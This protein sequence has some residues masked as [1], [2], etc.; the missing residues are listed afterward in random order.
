[1]RRTIA[2]CVP[3]LVLIALSGSPAPAQSW[4]IELK[5]TADGPEVARSGM[6]DAGFN[7]V[8]AEHAG[9]KVACGP[10]VDCARVAVKILTGSGS[11]LLDLGTGSGALSVFTIPKSAATDSELALFYDGAST[12]L[13]KYLLAAGASSVIP[14]EPSPSGDGGG[15]TVT[16]PLAELLK[17]ECRA[18]GSA[19]YSTKRNRGAIVVSP[20]GQVSEGR[21]VEKF[22]ENDTLE[23]T[24]FGHK[25]LL[26]QLKVRRKSP[27]GTG[28]L[29]IVGE[30]L[31]IPVASGLS[32][33]SGSDVCGTRTFT[34]NNFAPGRGEVEIAVHDG[35]GDT[36]LG[37]FEFKVN[38]LYFGIFSLGGVWTDMVDPEFKLVSDGADSILSAGNQGDNEFLYSVMFTPYIWGK[39][40]LEKKT[41]W[42]RR[43]NPTVGLV[44][45]DVEDH[46]LVGLTFD[47][48]RGFLVTAGKHY[49]KISV[50]DE[51]SGL[52]EGDV[53]TGPVD[54]LPI[55]DSW[56][57]DSFVSVSIDLRVAVKM[58]ASAF[59]GA[60]GGK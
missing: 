48:P 55:S 49:R 6:D 43:I 58:F 25:A 4:T 10:D 21:G 19:R 18:R 44:L 33:Q 5:N 50:I 11:V 20:T 31:K 36:V 42:L 52:S 13:T 24:V 22:D 7:T 3:A 16:R 40:D 45:D 15:G 12:P 51:N 8:R 39:R 46:G 28:E 2:W 47:L 26:D 37:T 53:F 27:F 57:D 9:L 60:G 14:V 41:G 56:E 34:L 54:Q 29:R 17:A 30:G 38:P 23:V 59:R 35:S 1:M 32:R